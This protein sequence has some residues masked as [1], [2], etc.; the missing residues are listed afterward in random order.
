MN[1]T[2]NEYVIQKAISLITKK[3]SF[4]TSEPKPT[5]FHCIR[6][7]TDLYNRW[8]DIDIVLAWFLHDLLEDSD[9]LYEEILLCFWKNVA[10]IV[11]ANSHDTSLDI[12][13]RSKEV[14]DRALSRKDATIVMCAEVLD[15]LLYYKKV[16]HA[17]YFKKK[18]QKA[19]YILE[20]NVYHDQK[21]IDLKS[22]ISLHKSLHR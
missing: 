8:Y 18:L 22:F 20:N 4:V 15:W 7:W 16:S 9:T 13:E 21:I 11:Q 12:S 1:Y 5:L 2:E 3:L 6:V 19:S 17:Q 10:D 14:V